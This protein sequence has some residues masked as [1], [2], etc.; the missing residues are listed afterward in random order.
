VQALSL[1]APSWSRQECPLQGCV[2]GYRDVDVLDHAR[3]TGCQQGWPMV[4]HSGGA[5]GHMA[6]WFGCV[7][8]SIL[9]AG[10]L[11]LF[12]CVPRR[13]VAIS[14]QQSSI[15]KQKGQLKAGLDHFAQTLQIPS[16]CFSQLS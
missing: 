16:S 1:R 4:R 6:D 13:L 14:S 9:P 7:S 8:L 11:R 12:G 3:K 10:R 5:A 15:V 2:I